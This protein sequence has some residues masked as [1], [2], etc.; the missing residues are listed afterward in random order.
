MNKFNQLLPLETINTDEYAQTVL[1]RA[2]L[3]ETICTL[4]DR[5]VSSKPY[6]EV[7]WCRDGT[8]AS[9]EKFP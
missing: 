2:H 4:S 6:I 3:G 5:K 1:N 9:Y 8:S 7:F